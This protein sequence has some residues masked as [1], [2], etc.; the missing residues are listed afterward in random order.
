[1]IFTKNL[2]ERIQCKMEENETYFSVTS[3]NGEYIEFDRKCD[4]IDRTDDD[5]C[6]FMH[7]K[8][9]RYDVLALIPYNQIR[10]IRNMAWGW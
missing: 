2:Q 8:D 4:Y 5:L 10:Y 1:M 3:I 6:I 9:E 7:K